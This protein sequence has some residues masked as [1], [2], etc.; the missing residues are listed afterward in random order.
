MGCYIEISYNLDGEKI[1][2]GII[3][4]NLNS[5]EELNYNSLSDAI[6][7]LDTNQLNELINNL[8]PLN[9]LSTKV[10]Y[11]NGDELIGNN[12]LQNIQTS[13]N[14]NKNLDENLV[15]DF[16]ILLYKLN[17]LGINLN[18]IQLLLLNG[19]DLTLT[20]NDN[21]ENIRGVLL[22][23]NFIILNTNGNFT[24]DTLKDLYHECLHLYFTKINKSDNNFSRINELAYN[25]YNT[26]KINKDSNPYIKEFITKVT[27]ANG[28]YDLNEF[29]AYIVSEP[30]YRKVLNLEGSKEYEEFINRLFF[31]NINPFILGKN[32]Q[33]IENVQIISEY[34]KPKIGDNFYD[35]DTKERRV[36]TEKDL[37]EKLMYDKDNNEWFIPPFVGKYDSEY[38][39]LEIPKTEN[40]PY[41]KIS[42]IIW[43][44][45][46]SS[47][48][49]NNK[50]DKDK[51]N[52]NYS[53]SV[54]IT[55]E[56]QLYNLNPGDLLLIPNFHKSDKEII[57]GNFDD[58][59]FSYTKYFP[60]QSVWKNRN[61][62]TFITLVNEY[63]NK[64]IGHFTISY[65]D[66]VRLMSERRKVLS[67]KKSYGIL[68]NNSVS[69]DI[70]K[71]VKD[72][73]ENN[74]N[75]NDINN[76]P[77]IKTINFNRKGEEFKYY[78]I[79]KGGF[80]LDTA[81]GNNELI[82]QDLKQN[83]IVKLRTWK[84]EDE[85]SE[86]DSFTY[87]APV[88][89]TY[90]TIVEVALKNK[91]GKYFSK[92]IPFKNI[93]SVIFT[94]SNHP[95]LTGLHRTFTENYD[96][97]YEDT[98]NKSL[99]QTV[100]FNL[101][102]LKEEDRRYDNLRGD[103]NSNL[104]RQTVIDFRREKVK[105]LNI[106]DSISVE[107]NM[108][109]RDGTPVISKHIV[110]GI[111]NDKIYFL[112]KNKTQEGEIPTTYVSYV[113]LKTVNP[114]SY[115]EY[116]KTINIPSLAAIH[117]NN[118]YDIDLI[119]DLKNKRK[120][121]N[122]SFDK[123]KKHLIDAGSIVTLNKLYT[124][125]NIDKTNAN[126][127]AS[128]LQRGDFITFDENGYIFTGIVSKYD[129]INGTILVPGSYNSGKYEGFTYRKIITPEQLIQIGFNKVPNYSLGIIGRSESEYNKKRLSRLYDLNHNTY[130]YILDEIL[131]KKNSLNKNNEW[132]RE[133]ES[134]YVIP[135]G[136][137]TRE[138]KESYI[139]SKRK[140][141][142]SGKIL[143]LTSK[144]KELINSGDLIDL[145]SEYIKANNIQSDKIYGLINIKTGTQIPNSTGYNQDFQIYKRSSDQLKKLLQVEDIIKIKYNY[146][147]KYS[148][149]LRIISVTDSG[150]NVESEIVGLDGN[151]YTF[152]EYINFDEIGKRYT[153]TELYYPSNKYRQKVFKD[154]P[155]TE[156]SEVSDNKYITDNYDKYDRK[157]LLQK[158]IDNINKNFG[159]II[160]V[161]DTDMILEYVEN[162]KL[163]KELGD[164]FIRSGAF[165][166]NGNIYV[167]IDKA[168]ISSPIH[169]LLHI[170]MGVMRSTSPDL[171]RLLID[172]ASSLPGFNEKFREILTNRT[173]SDAKEEA[174][175]D[176]IANS[177][178]GV[179][180]SDNFDFNSLVTSDFFKSYFNILNIGLSLEMNENISPKTLEIL[181]KEISNMSIEQIVKEF[182]S[183]LLNFDYIK[184]KNN[185][186]L[187]QAF[188][189][190]NVTNIK[191]SLLNSDNVNS[192]LIE[193]C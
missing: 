74:I 187:N 163:N 159:N 101:N 142:P 28:N 50:F 120:S 61:G 127:E 193:N 106:G 156:S 131:K 97:Y 174:F 43:K 161:I 170:I 171:Y 144:I 35:L 137:T 118:K 114:Y 110:I 34:P 90:G 130:D 105:G 116:G 122:E 58:K 53:E 86:W 67:F 47:I 8:T 82:V 94:K 80:K 128:K 10:K 38:I 13:I 37:K 25:I 26:A 145:T 41:S 134:V 96:K 140:V 30:I 103:F 93:E 68:K 88:I 52:L 111:S 24:N 55:S 7:S 119:N 182:N 64:G 1:I 136:V 76:Q 57:Y 190:R 46:I 152:T 32:S 121:I 72:N 154:T 181:S 62:E 23:N 184:L 168:N 112:N 83:D 75:S 124:F 165:I 33:E 31:I 85:N 138:F 69:E 59:Y 117:Y 2:G 54:E 107:W 45:Y 63:G 141:L 12:T 16:N 126:I 3:P 56:I 129:P 172:K 11:Y 169:E 173:L 179:F 9:L 21:V 102:I 162:N 177:L 79:G 49:T 95:D 146:D 18:N 92:R 123:Y 78:K 73:Y 113:D 89:R 158:V 65:T 178:S 109:K 176:A 17:D 151:V 66:L 153:I 104:N 99:Y 157:I 148:R 60:I 143:L 183:I 36:I 164:S 139:N 125:I 40:I 15:D 155:V 77:L 147:N 70:I 175:V 188:I 81:N 150:I 39:E 108:K 185:S 48:N 191:T 132:V 189:N 115:K 14:S 180:T 71:Q 42:E 51:Y 84:K 6:C 87:Y 100:W 135:K 29:I 167:N 192:K 91:S 160:N 19:E 5:Y 22:N 20:I 133:F 44:N 4:I 186:A 149:Y 27:N 166:Y 98:K